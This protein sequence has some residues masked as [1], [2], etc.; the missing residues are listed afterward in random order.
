V[1][2]NQDRVA[3]IRAADVDHLTRPAEHRLEGLPHA[4]RGDDPVDVGDD[5]AA[6]RVDILGGG[7][8][9]GNRRREQHNE[10]RHRRTKHA[11]PKPSA[12]LF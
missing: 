8:L 2:E 1:D 7:R 4:V 3:A 6:G 11:P 5:R 10:Q 9:G 12:P